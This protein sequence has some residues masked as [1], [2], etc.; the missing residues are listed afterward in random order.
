M[1]RARTVGLGGFERAVAVK[2]M[3]AGRASQKRFQDMLLDEARLVARLQ[4]PNVAQIW[5]VGE[6]PRS[7]YFVMELVDGASLDDL[8]A[9]AED[10]GKPLPIRAVFRVLADA[11]AGLHTAH[12]LTSDG[13]SMGIVHRDISPHNILVTKDGIAKLI[14]FG[15]AK[16]RERLAGDTSTGLIKGKISFMAPEQAKAEDLDRRADVFAMGAVAFELIEG[17]PPFDGQTEVGRLAALVGPAPAPPLGERVPAPL[18]AVVARALQKDRDARYSTAAELKEAIEEALIESE[19]ETSTTEV[20]RLLA[21]YFT[22][23]APEPT[24]ELQGAL[25]NTTADRPVSSTIQVAPVKTATIELPLVRRRY[26]PILAPVALALPVLAW[27]VTR[28]GAT[29]PGTGPDPSALASAGVASATPTA[30]GA[31]SLP[32][33]N[34][35]TAPPPPASASPP[36]ASASPPPASAIGTSASAMTSD[37]PVAPSVQKPPRKTGR[38]APIDEDAIE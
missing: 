2:V 17:R 5:E 35:T 24:S 20:A 13:V 19:L 9:R 30:P 28:P 29:S 15:I 8:F 16:A 38:H 10:L 33:Q 12:E 32:S 25:A 6:D 1:W 18:R 4:H 7:L 36:P 14:D 31:S 23:S 37:A 27:A 26:W 22:R 21:P 3:R 11:C 34:E